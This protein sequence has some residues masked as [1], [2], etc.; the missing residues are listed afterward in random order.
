MRTSPCLT[1]SFLSPRCFQS[2]IFCKLAFSK[3]RIEL[4]RPSVETLVELEFWVPST[5]FKLLRKV[6]VVIAFELCG[7]EEKKRGEEKITTSCSNATRVLCFTDVFLNCREFLQHSLDM[8]ATQLSNCWHL[9]SFWFLSFRW[10]LCIPLQSSQVVRQSWFQA[11]Y[12]FW[13]T[14]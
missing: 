9:P 6:K 3:M 8:F 12:K 1:T 14:C 10:L 7:E 5:I 13:G 11:H 2:K 4:K